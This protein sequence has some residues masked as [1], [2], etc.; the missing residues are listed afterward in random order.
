MHGYKGK[1]FVLVKALAKQAGLNRLTVQDLC[2]Q[3]I[4]PSY[5]PHDAENARYQVA[6][7]DAEAFLQLLEQLKAQA[8]MKM[9]S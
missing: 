1:D 5:R 6:L 9:A 3:G 4:I 8:T 2:R 7:E